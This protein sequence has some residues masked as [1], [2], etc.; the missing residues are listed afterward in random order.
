MLQNLGVSGKRISY[1]EDTELPAAIA[2]KPDVVTI[3]AGPNDIIHGNEPEE[4]EGPLRNVLHQLREQ[5]SALVVI[6][7]VP[8][9]TRLPRFMLDPDP[10]VT[11]TKIVAYNNIIAQE[12]AAYSVPV[13]DLFAGGYASEWSY[14]SLDGFHPSNKGHAKIAELYLDIILQYF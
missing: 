13:V 11:I 14:V 1:I 3:W 5:T 6:A 4:F 8:D 10:D 12:A 7:N 9:L 2:Y